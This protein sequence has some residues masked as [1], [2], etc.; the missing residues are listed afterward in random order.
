VRRGED[1]LV[2]ERR[3]Q[4]VAALHLVGVR[5]GVAGERARVGAQAR[6]L[7]A[8]PA[9]GDLVEQCLG[10]LDEKP[11]L[12]GLRGRDRL[13]QLGRPVVRVDDSVDV[14][15]EPEAEQEVALGDGSGHGTSLRVA[16]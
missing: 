10:V 7:V 11:R 2:G 16:P 6:G 3:P 15:A 13:G 1:V 5:G 9:V 8:E 4:P 14:T 12:D